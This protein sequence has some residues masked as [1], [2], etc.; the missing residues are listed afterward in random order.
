MNGV[1]W[2]SKLAGT[3]IITIVAGG[4]Y[5]AIADSWETVS[6]HCQPSPE[7]VVC[8]ISGEPYPGIQ[9][10]IAIPKTQLAGIK[11]IFR[12]MEDNLVQHLVLTTID[13]QEIPLNIHPSGH[14][15]IQLSQ[16]QN[17]I[18]AF[19]ANPQAQTLSI[20]TQRN[21]PLPL[22]IITAGMIGMSGFYLKK[23]WIDSK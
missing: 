8:K 18:A 19:L 3:A 11:P 13:R 6:L 20:T 1:S 21:F 17:K 7:Q 16:Q 12:L 14:L 2:I 5:L 23:L 4:W 10:N 22:S 15:T 9:R